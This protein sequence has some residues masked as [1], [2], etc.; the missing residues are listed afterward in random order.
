VREV[1]RVI[2]VR[3]EARAAI[4]AALDQVHRDTGEGCSAPAGHRAP[5]D[6]GIPRCEAT[7]QPNT[8]KICTT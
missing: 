6:Y 8:T 2:L 3:K 4:V 1:K 5:Q 7:C